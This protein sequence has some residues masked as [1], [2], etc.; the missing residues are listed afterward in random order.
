MFSHL[1]FALV[2]VGEVVLLTGLKWVG[3]GWESHGYP[4][5]N[6]IIIWG[7]LPGGFLSVRP[8]SFYDDTLIWAFEA[9]EP[10][11]LND[12]MTH[13]IINESMH[14][15]PHRRFSLKTFCIL[16]DKINIDANCQILGR[17]ATVYLNN[18][19]FFSAFWCP[20]TSQSL[21]CLA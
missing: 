1:V 17:A 20:S 13:I 19:V 9:A 6:Q 10:H 7:R 3:S 18:L 5:S 12:Y 4:C 11:P 21:F 16:L 14:S 2:C 15:R 8:Q